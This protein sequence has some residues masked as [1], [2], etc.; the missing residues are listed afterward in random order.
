METTIPQSNSQNNIRWYAHSTGEILNQ[1]ATSLNGLSMEESSQRITTCGLNQFEAEE[2]EAA[3]KQLLGQ[4]TNLLIIILIVA[5]VVSALIGEYVESIAIIIIVILAGVLGFIQ[6]Y[7][8]GK[9]IESLK[10]LA[11][12][13]ATA[14]RDGIEQ[15]VKAELLVPGDLIVL[16][17]GYHIPADARII[18]S[19]N[20]KVDETALTGESLAVE[21]NDYVLTTTEDIPLGDRK[22]LLYLGTSVVYGRGKAVVVATGMK[23]EFG[24]I[25]AMLQAT[26][27]RR[28]PL[29]ENLDQLGKKIG[30]FAIVV[31]VAMSLFEILRGHPIQEM[32]VWGVALAVAIIPEAL[33]AVVT[34]TL[35]LGVRRMV[36]RRALIRKLPAV[37]TLGATNIICSDKTGT[38]TQDEMTIRK[39]VALPHMYELTGAGYRPQGKFLLNGQPIDDNDRKQLDF[40]LTAGSLCNDTVLKQH[41]EDKSWSIFG[42]PTEGALVVAAKKAMLDADELRIKYARSFEV[43]FSSESKR[44]TTVHEMQDEIIAFSKGAPEVIIE[45]CTSVLIDGKESPM[46]EETKKDIL[47]RAQQM[48]EEALRVLAISYRKIEKDQMLSLEVQRNHVF[49]GLVGMIDPPRPEVKS[50][51]KVCKSAGIKP[52]MITGDHKVTAVA[53]ARE[54]GILTTGNAISGIDLEK[55]SD[56]ELD[57]IVEH[58]EVYARIAPAHKLRI[59]E[60]LMRKGHIVAMT[61]DGVNDA[62]ALKK[63]DIGVAMGINGTDVSREASDMILTD[64]NF[65]SIVAAVEE[66][67]SIFENIRKYLVY[68]LSGNMGGVFAIMACSVS[69][70]PIPLTAA[71]ILFIN[72]LMDGMIA[73]ALGLEPPEPRMMQRMP[74]NVKEGILNNFSMW[75]IFGLGVW[76][77]LSLMGVYVWALNVAHFSNTEASTLFFATLI[78]ARIFNG[79]NCRSLSQSVF[80]INPVGNKPLL[81]SMAI[82]FLLTLASM[83]IGI[84]NEAFTTAPIM[85]TRWIPVLAASVTT[86]IVIELAK[87]FYALRKK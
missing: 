60:S 44:M 70:L 67:R 3:W 65:A 83:Y 57:N 52:I 8:A 47:A 46:N 54:L 41:P 20:L 31:A 26:D 11:A 14:I 29:Q 74:R 87:F 79:F 56:Q 58:T 22:N 34:I 78:M 28:T 5:A 85:V 2:K 71:Q 23:T 37:E 69:G 64:D 80:T 17:T 68:L 24:K 16:K 19:I 33:P 82:V 49:I 76:I 18:E 72:F 53:V 13:I 10:K 84:F 75:F 21:K 59:V 7:Q 43:P 4:F 77:A 73:I 9:A 50:A 12:P 42:D 35:A 61:G 25:A 55:L 1:L 48:G 15:H 38:L 81:W 40:L 27:T 51:I 39:I 6:E 86:L 63:A 62:P 36:K 66:G 32:F 30:I 45:S